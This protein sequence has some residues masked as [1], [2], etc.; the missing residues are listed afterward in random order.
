MTDASHGLQERSHEA[1]ADITRC[2]SQPSGGPQ[3]SEEVSSSEW[4]LEYII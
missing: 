4:S 2:R 3:D 1:N